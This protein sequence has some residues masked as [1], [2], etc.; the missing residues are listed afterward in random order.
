L[1]VL[2]SLDEVAVERSSVAIGVFDGV[3]RGH[4]KVLESA[5]SV[6]KELDCQTL[7]F[8]FDRLPS[9]LLAP[10]KAPL[11]LTS[12]SQKI[13]LIEK[14]QTIDTLVVAPFTPSLAHL[15]S[16]Q[17]VEKILCGKLK[18]KAVRVG[19]DFRYGR[20]R[21]GSVMDLEASGQIHGFDVS[22]VHAIVQDGERISSTHIRK[23]I[24]EGKVETAANLLGRF[25][26][27]RGSVVHGKELG[28]T[29]GFPTANLAPDDLRAALPTPGVYAGWATIRKSKSDA[30][31]KAAAAISVGVNPTIKGSDSSIKIEAHLMDGFDQD[32]YDWFIDLEFAAKLRG[33]KKFE[34]I[35]ALSEQLKRDVKKAEGILR[36]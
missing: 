14:T 15:K 26:A 3:H 36:G 10:E 18:A 17:F 31:I 29:I 27:L 22:I 4:Q 7:A 34:N 5:S 1:K 21:S 33:I 12:L 25:F 11:H 28:R 16:S 23:L 8:T 2:T 32:I 9:D 30:P 13:E 24:A 35:T 20:D 6:A 19:A